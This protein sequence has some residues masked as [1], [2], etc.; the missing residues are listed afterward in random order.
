MYD[1]LKNGIK[2]LSSV[3]VSLVVSKAELLFSR[4]VKLSIQ[5]LAD[6]LGYSIK[7]DV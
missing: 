5:Q 1:C 4:I 7:V 3:V 6:G 2:V